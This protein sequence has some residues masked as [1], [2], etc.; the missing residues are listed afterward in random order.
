MVNG[1]WNFPIKSQ[2]SC[3]IAKI[4]TEIK[5]GIR[6]HN[7]FKLNN[8]F[9]WKERSTCFHH[10]ARTPLIIVFFVYTFSIATVF[11]LLD[12]ETKGKQTARKQLHNFPGV[13]LLIT[14]FGDFDKMKKKTKYREICM[15]TRSLYII[16]FEMFEKTMFFCALCWPFLCCCY[17]CYSLCRFWLLLVCY[18]IRI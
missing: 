13:L 12:T 2:P 7:K 1:K 11:R 5:I 18:D 16:P 8:Q 15:R 10:R 4:H 9:V 14:I 6:T 17:Y 3:T